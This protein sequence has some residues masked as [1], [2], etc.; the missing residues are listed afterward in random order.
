MLKV[1]TPL[2][3]GKRSKN[4]GFKLPSRIQNAKLIIPDSRGF[5]FVWCGTCRINVLSPFDNGE[6]D[7]IEIPWVIK[8]ADETTLFTPE[9]AF[10]AIWKM[11]AMGED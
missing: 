4:P 1:F 8:D 7:Y 6:E 11:I 5:V 10:Q 9:L 3:G 2:K